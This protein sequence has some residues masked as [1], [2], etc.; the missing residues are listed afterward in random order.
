MPRV[1]QDKSVELHAIAF[2]G[3]TSQMYS[4]MKST[5][6]SSTWQFT[7]MTTESCT[8]VERIDKHVY[9]IQLY[10]HTTW[11]NHT[12]TS[13]CCVT[14]PEHSAEFVWEFNTLVMIYSWSWRCCGYYMW[15]DLGKPSMWDQCTICAILQVKNCQIPDF[16]ISISKNPSSNCY[17]CLRRLGMS[18]KGEICLHFDLRSQTMQRAMH[19]AHY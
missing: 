10:L 12:T 14:L 13:E 6:Y 5:V 9:H 18:C 4:W 16:V 3:V 11:L 17:R 2:S 1:D 19:R 7:Q 15:P 8:T